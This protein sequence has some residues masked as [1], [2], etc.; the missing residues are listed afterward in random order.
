MAPTAAPIDI[1]IRLANLMFPTIP[2][3]KASDLKKL[4]LLQNCC[5][6]N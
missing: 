6:T 3:L 5:Q 2:K 4:Q 1:S